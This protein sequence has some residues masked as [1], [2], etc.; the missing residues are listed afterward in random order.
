MTEHVCNQSFNFSLQHSQANFDVH[1]YEDKAADLIEIVDTSN[2]AC[3]LHVS[4][5]DAPDLSRHSQVLGLVLPRHGQQHCFSQW[6]SHN[7][8]QLTIVYHHLHSNWLL[9]KVSHPTRHKIGHF[10]DVPQANL[11][12]WYGKKQNLTQQKHTF[13]NQN[14]LLKQHKIN[15]KK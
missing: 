6:H 2:V 11:L 12:A 14:K 1:S 4:R 13:T 15:T 7:Y 10:G 9:V 8:I 3:N 5:T